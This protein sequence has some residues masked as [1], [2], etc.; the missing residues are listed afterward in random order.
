V[1]ENP[2]A[3]NHVGAW[4]MPTLGPKCG[5]PAG[6]HTPPWRDTSGDQ[7]GWHEWRRELGKHLEE[8]RSSVLAGRHGGERQSHSES[9]S[10]EFGRGQNGWR[11][12]G[13]PAARCKN[14]PAGQRG[15]TERSTRDGGR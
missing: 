6:L 2:L 3:G 9:P 7:R 10:G 13:T 4:W 14:E 8:R 11:P 12:S 1:A 5:W 15:P